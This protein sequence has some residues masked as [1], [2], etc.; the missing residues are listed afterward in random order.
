MFENMLREDREF[1]M[2]AEK[3]HRGDPDGQFSVWSIHLSCT[4]TQR[5]DTDKMPVFQ[6]LLAEFFET[7]TY[8]TPGMKDLFNY[9]DIQ[10]KDLKR[11][12]RRI[13]KWKGEG[14]SVKFDYGVELD[15]MISSWVYGVKDG[16]YGD[17]IVERGIKAIQDF[18]NGGSPGWE[19]LPVFILTK[20]PEVKQKILQRR[21]AKYLER[22]PM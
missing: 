9:M 5:Y 17:E 19:I 7:G 14:R 15:D 22:N 6:G 10:T 21:I 12:Q 3:E 13:L 16:G 4:G 8:D 2:R 11:M 18:F 20:V 1:M